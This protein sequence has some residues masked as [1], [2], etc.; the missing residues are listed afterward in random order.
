MPPKPRAVPCLKHGTRQVKRCVPHT[1]PRSLFSALPNQL[2]TTLVFH[3]HT[4]QG[5]MEPFGWSTS[6]RRRPRTAMDPRGGGGG[7]QER[8]ELMQEEDDN[9]I[10]WFFSSPSAEMV[11]YT[12]F[13]Q[14]SFRQKVRG[15]L[16]GGGVIVWLGGWV[17]A[18]SCPFD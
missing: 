2:T 8:R 4:A 11:D 1:P 15:R 6:P 16:R 17:A 9:L 3:T 13:H 5:S 18:S 14:L 7:A 12:S 10:T